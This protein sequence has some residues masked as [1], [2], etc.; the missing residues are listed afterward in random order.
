MNCC[1]VF[2]NP[3]IVKVYFRMCTAFHLGIICKFIFVWKFNEIPGNFV[4]LRGKQKSPITNHAEPTL[5]K[6]CNQKR[7]AREKLC[8]FPKSWW[9]FNAVKY[10]RIMYSLFSTNKIY[11]LF[12]L[13]KRL[14]WSQCWRQKAVTSNMGCDGGHA[15]FQLFS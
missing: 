1:G 3:W 14:I 15:N 9:N 11:C 12:V 10:I 6:E 5:C 7:T 13:L 4:F 8:L 2:S